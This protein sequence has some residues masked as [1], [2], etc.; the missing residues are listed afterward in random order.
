[1]SVFEY[2]T[3]RFYDS[4]HQNVFTVDLLSSVTTHTAGFV[5]SHF[6]VFSTVSSKRD[7]AYSDL[8][9]LQIVRNNNRKKNRLQRHFMYWPS[10][11]AAVCKH[12]D[13]QT[14]VD[15]NVTHFDHSDRTFWGYKKYRAVPGSIAI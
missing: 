4:E 11:R 7:H 1:M 3:A 12:A 2:Q 9:C 5:S 15:L 10:G 14:H 8:C 6:L 13:P